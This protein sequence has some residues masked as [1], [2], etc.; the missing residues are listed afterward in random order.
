MKLNCN[1]LSLGSPVSKTLCGGGTKLKFKYKYR[2]RFKEKIWKDLCSKASFHTNH[3]REN[4]K[5]PDNLHY[6][7]YWTIWKSYT[8]HHTDLFWLGVSER[9]L[10]ICLYENKTKP[11]NCNQINTKPVLMSVNYISMQITFNIKQEHVFFYSNNVTIG[12]K[13]FRAW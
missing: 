10:N 13:F 9:L 12:S 4:Y 11:G 5:L 8:F 1:L 3:R 7:G 6:K 2:K